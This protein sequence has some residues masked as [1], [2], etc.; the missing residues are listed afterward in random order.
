MLI[1]VV[2]FAMVLL[3]AVPC[4]IFA[5]AATGRA[6]RWLVVRPVPHSP[7]RRQAVDPTKA[8]LN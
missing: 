4:A 8:A 6:G 1:A 3:V 2:L 5:V 7:P